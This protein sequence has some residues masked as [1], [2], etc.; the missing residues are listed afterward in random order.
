MKTEMKFGIHLAQQETPMETPMQV[1]NHSLKL[2]TELLGI[3]LSQK[4]SN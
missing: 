2:K 1:M 3:L 4:I